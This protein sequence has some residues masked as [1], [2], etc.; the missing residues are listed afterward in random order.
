MVAVRGMGGPPPG[1]GN[2]INTHLVY[3]HGF[4]FVAAKADTVAAGGTPQFVESD[5][6]PHGQLGP[7]QPRVYFGQQEN[8]LR[9]RRRAAR[10][11]RA[12]TRLPRRERQRPEELHLQRHRRRGGGL[13]AEPFPVRRQVP[14]A[15]HP[16]VRR[17]QQLLEDPLRPPAAG[18]GGQGGPVPDAGRHPVPGGRQR[19]HP[20]GGGRLHDHRHVSVFRTHQHAAGHVHQP[21]PERVGR[22][23]AD[24]RDQLHPQLGQGGG[25]RLHRGRHASTSGALPTRCSAPG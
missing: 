15:E 20:V 5:I 14:R 10:P 3:T 22:R 17:H 24:R 19:A 4:G 16:A 12:G 21:D 18:P 25:G 1:Q 6:P 2:W 7:F 8:P 11:A 9:D 23:A 13:P